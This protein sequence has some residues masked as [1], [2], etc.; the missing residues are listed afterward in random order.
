MKQILLTIRDEGRAVHRLVAEEVVDV[1]I[2][3]LGAEPDTVEELESA[4]ARYMGPG[5][6]RRF[7]RRWPDGVDT[8]TESRQACV[9]DL[10]GRLVV[11]SSA[12]LL[13][14]HDGLV[15]YVDGE[16]DGRIWLGYAISAD[17][18]LTAPLGDWEATSQQRRQERAALPMIDTRVILYGQLVPFIV[19]QCFALPAR[20]A[21][22][23]EL[24]RD[25]HRR[26]LTLPRVDLQDLAP[27][28][29]L[30]AR[31]EIIDRDLQD[32]FEQWSRLGECPP[33]LSRESRAFR[34]AGF[35]TNE[36]VLY[37]DLCRACSRLLG[38]CASGPRYGP[39]AGDCP[40][41]EHPAGLAVDATGGLAG[42]FP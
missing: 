42:L 30:L 27:R 4:L 23:Q 21:S 12:R 8:G 34:L 10:P 31:R 9:V 5:D 25:I 18:L 36:I 28:D 26:W 33:G 41:G 37:Y 19:Q 17:W 16:R 24:A 13:P 32:R 20:S 29:W 22:D 39:P 7:L 1:V 14:E 3:A 38:A 2:A 35:G 6:E 11:A 40:S 15:T